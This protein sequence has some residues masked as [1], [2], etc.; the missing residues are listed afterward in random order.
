MVPLD[1]F[2]VARR[3]PLNYQMG[4]GREQL[5]D[6]GQGPPRVASLVNENNQRAFYRRWA[7]LMA[8]GE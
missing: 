5:V 6:D 4:L 7:E 2:A 3:Y 8:D 1:G